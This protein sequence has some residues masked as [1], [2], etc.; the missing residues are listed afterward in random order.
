[1]FKASLSRLYRSSQ[2]HVQLFSVVSYL[3]VSILALI[4]LGPF[5]IGYRLSR[6]SGVPGFRQIH[7]R[8]LG[9]FPEQRSHCVLL[10]TATAHHE[11]PICSWRKSYVLASLLKISFRGDGMLATP[12]DSHKPLNRA[13]T[14]RFSLPSGVQ[15]SYLTR[16]ALVRQEALAPSRARELF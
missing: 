16:A 14:I 8:S 1:M 12:Q 6:P 3:L 9:D 11:P 5:M 15:N 7:R 4:P 13:S 2:V 10:W